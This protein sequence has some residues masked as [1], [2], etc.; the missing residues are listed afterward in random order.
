MNLQRCREERDVL[1]RDQE[2][3]RES[4]AWVEVPCP[5]IVDGTST[6]GNEYKTFLLQDPRSQNY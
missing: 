6:L 4:E 1:G 5:M 3:P 2:A